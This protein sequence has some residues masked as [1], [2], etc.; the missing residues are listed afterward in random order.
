MLVEA[1]SPGIQKQ[2]VKPESLQSMEVQYEQILQK[3][4]DIV[5]VPCQTPLLNC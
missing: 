2:M 4:G 3:L 1:G 5:K